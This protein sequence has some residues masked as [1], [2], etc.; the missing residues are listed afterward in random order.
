MSKRRLSKKHATKGLRSKIKSSKQEKHV[1]EVNSL[2][3]PMDKLICNRGLSHIAVKIFK[4][5]ENKSLAN[6][7]LVS[8]AWRDCIDSDKH[9]WRLQLDEYRE[10]G[11][12]ENHIRDGFGYRRFMKTINDFMTAFEYIYKNEPVHNLKSFT[13]FMRDYCRRIKKNIK[14]DEDHFDTPL[15]FVTET[16]ASEVFHLVVPFGRWT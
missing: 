10:L 11:L 7:R 9:W 4:E 16:N 6:C 8:K 1:I 12:D 13:I 15:S 5:L 14:D 2:Y 3:F